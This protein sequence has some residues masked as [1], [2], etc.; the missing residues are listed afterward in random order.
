MV[1]PARLTSSSGRTAHT[2]SSSSRSW[3]SWARRSRL[4]RVSATGRTVSTACRLPLSSRRH[5][6]RTTRSPSSHKNLRA[7]VRV[8]HH[9]QLRRQASVGHVYVRLAL[10]LYHPAQ[11]A[12]QDPRNASWSLT[13]PCSGVSLQEHINRRLL[14][15]NSRHHKR[16]AQKARGPEGPRPSLLVRFCRFRRCAFPADGSTVPY[17]PRRSPPS[18]SRWCRLLHPIARAAPARPCL[19]HLRNPMLETDAQLLQLFEVHGAEY[20]LCRLPNAARRTKGLDVGS[21][22][23]RECL[24]GWRLSL[25]NKLE[26]TTRMPRPPTLTQT[27]W[28]AASDLTDAAQAGGR[29]Q[30]IA[31]A[32][33]AAPIC[34]RYHSPSPNS[35]SHSV[36]R[37]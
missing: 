10:C 11:I 30:A 35:T 15:T 14:L 20:Q 24:R 13:L 18:S 32:A 4:A 31:E 33:A 7:A 2:A 19:S 12:A 34:F 5:P 21:P 27:F 22:G 26:P 3:Y 37:L 8:R 25:H 6:R 9:C 16:A 23:S 28:Q 1:R 29:L 36:S 17:R